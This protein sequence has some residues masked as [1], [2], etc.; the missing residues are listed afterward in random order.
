MMNHVNLLVGSYSPTPDFGLT[1]KEAAEASVARGGVGDLL[2]LRTYRCAHLSSCRRRCPRSTSA[3][4]SCYVSNSRTIYLSST[5]CDCAACGH[6]ASGC[7][8]CARE[9]SGCADRAR[10]ACASVAGSSALLNKTHFCLC[11]HKQ[12]RLALTSEAQSPDLPTRASGASEV[13]YM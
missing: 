11:G 2:H 3:Q 6:V 13:A 4:T 1:Q 7:A 8:G 5:G 10:G 12:A 9:A